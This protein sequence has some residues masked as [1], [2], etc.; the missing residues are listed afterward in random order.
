MTIAKDIGKYS[1]PSIKIGKYFQKASLNNKE[2][3]KP[4]I[5]DDKMKASI[6]AAVGVG[7]VVLAS[8]N[9]GID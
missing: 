3:E 1:N 5:I 9:S 8:Q 6:V 4:L 7:A 2:T